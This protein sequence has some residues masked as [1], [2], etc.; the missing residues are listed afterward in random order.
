MDD[1]WPHQRAA[2][3]WLATAKSGMLHVPMGGGKTR[4]AIEAFRHHHRVLVVCP[5]AVVPT[6]VAE[7]QRWAGLSTLALDDGA[8]ARR[9]ELLK[10]THERTPGPLVVAMNYEA[11]W[12]PPM[13]GVVESI[14]WDAVVLDESQR[15]KTPSAKAARFLA[16]LRDKRPGAMVLALTGTPM[17]HGPLDM[18][19]QLRATRPDV[20]TRTFTEWRGRYAITGRLGPWHVVGYRNLDEMATRIQPA[21]YR[22]DA[23]TLTRPDLVVQTIPVRLEPGAA[24]IYRHLEDLF[25]AELQDGR[26]TAT[27]KLTQLLRL[28]Q[29]T[30]G[31]VRA[32]D[33]EI[34]KV[35]TAKVAALRELVEDLPPGEPLVVFGVFH[36]D[37][38]AVHDVA[39]DLGTTSAELSGRVNQ[40]A[41]WQCPDGPQI[42]AVQLRAGS[43]GVSMV[44]AH[45]GVF[46]SMGYSLGD[47]E[48]AIARL[49]RPGQN[50][51]VTMYR[52]AAE[53]TVDELVI[54]AI[55]KKADVAEFVAA[56]L[57]GVAADA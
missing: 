44:R 54:R 36:A 46:F 6:W 55:D 9:A 10:T 8:I 39:A 35:S 29:I 45:Y 56:A 21:V 34:V 41:E 49:R 53:H 7:T 5:L 18:W 17:P 20:V 4:I 30:S 16:R 15:A 43:V 24:K 38:D 1:L 12:R 48:Q 23:A 27:N 2:I 22:V 40:L 13:A 14:P 33:G 31:A 37:L 19:A 50:H 28:Q 26:I 42:L 51:P 11:V 57:S 25:V 32:D 47:Y 3:D 52:L